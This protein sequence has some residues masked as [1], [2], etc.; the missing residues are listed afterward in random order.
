MLL[1]PPPPPP[2]SSSSLPC[3]MQQENGRGSDP[4]PSFP[5]PFP[6]LGGAS[7][8]CCWRANHC[9]LYK[10]NCASTVCQS[11]LPLSVSQSCHLHQ[12]RRKL[13]TRASP[14]RCVIALQVASSPA[15]IA[16][17]AQVNLALTVPVEAGFPPDLP[18][19]VSVNHA[20][21]E[22]PV[23]RCTCM[24]HTHNCRAQGAPS[25][26]PHSAVCA[27]LWCGGRHGHQDC[28]VM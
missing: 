11:N 13:P 10:Y 27:L 24:R 18:T 8:N 17:A 19:G 22:G 6:S 20:S 21:F 26:A 5:F 15:G 23:F 12:I 16:A 14:S 9:N 25:T 2:I 28:K 4:P 1:R 3:C 7:K